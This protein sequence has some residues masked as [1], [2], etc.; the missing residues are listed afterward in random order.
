MFAPRRR[1]LRFKLRSPPSL[2]P[3]Q[4]S[5]TLPAGSGTSTSHTAPSLRPRPSLQLASSAP[6]REASPLQRASPR[7]LFLRHPQSLVRDLRPQADASS[8]STCIPPSALRLSRRRATAAAV[9]P[10]LPKDTWERQAIP[11]HQELVE[12]TAALPARAEKAIFL[13]ASTSGALPAPQRALR[14]QAPRHRK[15]RLPR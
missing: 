10:T 13:P 11:D 1:R 3:R 7:K 14:L 9:S 12:A 2:R 8:R 15:L 5:R 4:A 6:C